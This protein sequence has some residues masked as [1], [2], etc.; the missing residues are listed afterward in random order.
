MKKLLLSLLTLFAM[1]AVAQEAT[2]EQYYAANA[3]IEAEA[4]YHIYTLYD[5]CVDIIDPDAINNLD[6]DIDYALAYDPSSRR[7]H[8]GADDIRALRFAVRIYDSAG[9]LQRTF[10]ACDGMSLI[11]LPP[12]LYIITWELNG[13]RHTV[14]VN[15]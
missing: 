14:K 15:R 2:D 3:A 9:R 6:G 11:N 10:Q 8:F 12:G 5:G 1:S 4:T 13:R 7:L